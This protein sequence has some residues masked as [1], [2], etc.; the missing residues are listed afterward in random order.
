[1]QV[2]ILQETGLLF[3]RMHLFSRRISRARTSLPEGP[4][5]C[6]TKCNYRHH[7]FRRSFRNQGRYQGNTEDATYVLLLC[8]IMSRLLIA[9]SQKPVVDADICQVTNCV[10]H[11]HYWKALSVGWRVQRWWVHNALR[12]MCHRTDHVLDRPC[13]EE[14]GRGRSS[15]GD[16]AHDTILPATRGTS[17]ERGSRRG[18]PIITLHLSCT[19]CVVALPR[20]SSCSD[21][22]G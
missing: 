16:P 2:C 15:T 8:G 11:V 7:S 6:P 13:T 14:A 22:R 17:T 18:S 20:T 21:I 9:G 5:G 3:H 1:M 19:S 10:R 12:E 4:G